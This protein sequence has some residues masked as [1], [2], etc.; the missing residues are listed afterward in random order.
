MIGGILGAITGLIGAGLQ[1]SAQAAQQQIAWAQLIEARNARRE[2]RRLATAARQDQYG[3]RTSYDDIANEW[4]M[5]LTPMQSRISKA[6]EKEN[7]LQ[8]TEDAPE[9]RKQKRMIQQRARDAKEPYNAALAKFKYREPPKE[10]AIRGE[11]TNL[12]ASNEVAQG[13]ENQ[14]MLMRGALR[15]GRGQD[16]P[17]LIKATDDQLGGKQAE[18]ALK[19]RQAAREEASQRTSEHTNQYMPEIQMW[20]KLMEGGGEPVDIKEWTAG[21]DLNTTQG[22]MA[23]AMQQALANGSG[24]VGAAYNALGTAVGRSPDLSGIAQI[25]ARMGSTQ[26]YGRQGSGGTSIHY[27]D[28]ER[29]RFDGGPF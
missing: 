23:S 16:I 18:I 6:G 4:R 3:N 7:L 12:L 20:A 21:R 8:L 28:N 19:A 2:Q 27:R 17:Q 11:I 1:A 9:A 29:P 5:T 22:A 24:Q 13:K 14:A 10:D 25:L 15:L 26:A